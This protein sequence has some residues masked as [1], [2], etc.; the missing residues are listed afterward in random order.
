MLKLTDLRDPSLASLSLKRLKEPCSG[1]D[2]IEI[3]AHGALCM[4]R[5]GTPPPALLP[6]NKRHLEPGTHQRLPLGVQSPTVKGRCYDDMAT[7]HTKARADSGAAGEPTLGIGA[8]NRQKC[9]M[10]SKR[11]AQRPGEH[12][13]RFEDEHGI[14]S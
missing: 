5:P 6:D 13:S 8:P 3:F 11:H 1:A 14:T 10:R 9:F 7:S 2:M 12:I 4:H